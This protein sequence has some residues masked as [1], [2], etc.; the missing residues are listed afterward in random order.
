[1]LALNLI[2]H[3]EMGN[4]NKELH[5]FNLDESRREKHGCFHESLPL[6]CSIQAPNT[7]ELM[8]NFNTQLNYSST[9]WSV[10][11]VITNV[12]MCYRYN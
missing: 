10:L 11:W 9:V 4:Q 7:H 6:V 12:L 1:M 8:T 3:G 5:I 2:Q